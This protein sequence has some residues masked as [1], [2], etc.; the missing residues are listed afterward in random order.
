MDIKSIRLLRDIP[1]LLPAS[2]EYY[3]DWTIKTGNREKIGCKEY[4]SPNR[5]DF[6][7]ILFITKGASEFTLGAN[8]YYIDEPTI[9]FVH[10]S[11]IIS[12]RNLADESAGHFCLFKKKFIENHPTLKIEMDKYR[13]FTDSCKGVIHLSEPAVSSI[14]QL[15]LQMNEEDM[16]GGPLAEDALQAYVQLIM[17]ASSKVA[18]YPKPDA[19]TDEFKHVY[20]FFQLLE[21]ETSIINYTQ[22]IRI[23]TA[24]EFADNLA[25]HPNHL[26]F[27]LKKHTGQNVSTHIKSRLLEE[28]RKLLLQTG[29]T[30]QDI[31]YAIGFAEQSSFSQ[32]FK[33]N[34][35]I[36][37]AEF[38]RGHHV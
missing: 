31:G 6:Y 24:K 20:E 9:L 32:F 2:S 18:A 16:A 14:K 5:R 38:R 33:K 4:L 35:G 21:K 27:L 36:T 1:E 19:T 8:I 3:E 13:L 29:W 7:K 15:F 25:I 30:L 34:I 37:P 22:P 28:S 23:K 11:E 12:W 10:P 26:N 17:I